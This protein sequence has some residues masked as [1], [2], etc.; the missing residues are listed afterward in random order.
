MEKTALV[1]QL[2]NF[3][4]QLRWAWAETRTITIRQ[5]CLKSVLRPAALEHERGDPQNPLRVVTL[6]AHARIRAML[7]K[8]NRTTC[9]STSN[10]S[11]VSHQKSRNSS[12]SIKILALVVRCALCAMRFAL[13]AINRKR[14]HRHRPRAIY[15]KGC[16]IMPSSPPTALIG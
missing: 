7:P 15:R 8:R 6:N 16:S 11:N 5:G 2:H 1:D 14:K 4:L 12:K 9:A 3:I 13:R 10:V